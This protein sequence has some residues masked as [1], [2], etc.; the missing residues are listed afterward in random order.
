MAI[1]KVSPYGEKIMP[2]RYCVKCGH[3][4]EYPYAHRNGGVVCS[5]K[6]LEKID[7]DDGEKYP[8]NSRDELPKER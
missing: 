5:R 2:K 7:G 1:K 8:D 4:C 6:C 3:R